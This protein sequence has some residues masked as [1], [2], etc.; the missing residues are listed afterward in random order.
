MHCF[1]HNSLPP[2]PLFL[3]RAWEDEREGEEEEREM[4]E[5]VD[6]AGEELLGGE[7]GS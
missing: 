4:G 5:E 7:R 3:A 6:E 2:S 1:L